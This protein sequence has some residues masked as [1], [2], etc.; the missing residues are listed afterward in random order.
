[1]QVPTLS[2]TNLGSKNSGY[3]KK[4]YSVFRTKHTILMK[5]GKKTTRDTGKRILLGE[6]N[7]FWSISYPQIEISYPHTTIK[8]HSELIISRL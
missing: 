7:I 1:M 6:Y 3:E 2:R 5:E 8:N 4:D